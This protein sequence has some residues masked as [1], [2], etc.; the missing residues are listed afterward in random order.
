MVCL[1]NQNQN[2]AE[3][4]TTHGINDSDPIDLSLLEGMILKHDARR[5]ERSPDR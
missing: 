2:H 1:L 5:F 4:R 3:S